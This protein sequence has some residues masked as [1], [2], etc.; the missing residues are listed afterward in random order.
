MASSR[1]AR[2]RKASGPLAD[3]PGSVSASLRASAAISAMMPRADASSRVSVNDPSM[4]DGT[5][6]AYPA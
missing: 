5:R 2:A 3:L 1:A 6:T 4:P